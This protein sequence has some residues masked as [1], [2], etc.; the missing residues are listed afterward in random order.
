MLL[1]RSLHQFSYSL[2]QKNQ[3]YY[4]SITK[5][6]KVHKS[7]AAS[8]LTELTSVVDWKQGPKILCT[9]TRQ[10]EKS[11]SPSLESWKQSESKF[12]F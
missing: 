11:I 7:D 5:D 4:V 1:E 3:A 6:T 12:E 8:V 10:K 9:S 2:K